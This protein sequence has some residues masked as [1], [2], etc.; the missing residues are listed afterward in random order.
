MN[1]Q[2]KLGRIAGYVALASLV[3]ALGLSAAPAAA[4]AKKFDAFA[5]LEE[6]MKG[7]RGELAALQK[8]IDKA[9]PT[10]RQAGEQKADRPIAQTEIKLQKGAPAGG[11]SKT[12]T[13]PMKGNAP[14]V[15]EEKVG[16]DHRVR[17]HIAG[18]KYEDLTRDDAKMIERHVAKMQTSLRK[19]Q[20]EAK[21]LEADFRSV[22]DEKGMLACRKY[23]EQLHGVGAALNKLGPAGKASMQDVHRAFGDL[24]R[25]FE[26]A[27]Q[28]LIGLLLPAV[29][30]VREAATGR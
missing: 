20:G 15:V 12:Q 9:S 1:I 2:R 10:L 24:S 13:T 28:I 8:Q 5:N 21:Q 7:F 30:K 3:G 22:Q 14:S 26:G 25:S 4:A 16:P 27:E 23:T 19:M 6:E 18:V 17:K 11:A 29:L